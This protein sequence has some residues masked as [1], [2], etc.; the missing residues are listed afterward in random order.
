MISVS[1]A[2]GQVEFDMRRDDYTIILQLKSTAYER[3]IITQWLILFSPLRV[4]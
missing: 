3:V 2:T 4:F 1:V